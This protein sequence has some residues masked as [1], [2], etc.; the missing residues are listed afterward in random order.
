MKLTGVNLY[1]SVGFDVAKREIGNTGSGLW[2]DGG[3]LPLDALSGADLPDCSCHWI[4]PYWEDNDGSGS[5]Q[6]PLFNDG[7]ISNRRCGRR[8]GEGEG[9]EESGK[10]L[11]YGS[12]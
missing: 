12:I 10:G 6:S 11:H 3:G 8:R 4:A 2:W 9:Q 1:T 7:D 5:Q